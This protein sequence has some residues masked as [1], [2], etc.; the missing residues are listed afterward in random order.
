MLTR[1]NPNPKD[2]VV[3]RQASAYVV[4][5]GRI[6]VLTGLGA[7]RYPSSATTTLLAN[8]VAELRG[9]IV[10]ASLGTVISAG[11]WYGPWCTTANVPDCITFPAGT[12]LNVVNTQ[13]P[14]Y[15]RA[16]GYTAAA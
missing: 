4:P 6:F 15:G 3:I 8:S 2:M 7:F 9:G 1:F 14:F 10:G 16:Y 13:G 11:D 12:I 5:A